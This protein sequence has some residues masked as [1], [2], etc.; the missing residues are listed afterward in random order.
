MERLDAVCPNDWTFD[1]DLVPG[2]SLVV[3]GQLTVAGLTRC[4][5]GEAGDGEAASPKGA[6]SDAL[7]RCAVHFGIGRYLYELPKT[8]VAWDESRRSPVDAMSLPA[9]ALPEDERV[10]G[11]SHVLSAIRSLRSGL[12][13]DV[14]RLRE[15]YRHVKA[16]LD[17]AGAA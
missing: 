12:P 15:V 4:D 7:K 11:V 5:L 1:V 8:W 6:A 17:A 10:S 13:Q 14:A 2:A 3:K 16:A 9:W